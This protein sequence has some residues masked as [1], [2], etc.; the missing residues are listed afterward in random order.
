MATDKKRKGT[1]EEALHRLEGIVE[2]LEKGDVPLEE[3]L[4]LYEEG[5]RLSKSCGERLSQAELS[6]KR[7]GRDLEGNLKL[8]EGEGDE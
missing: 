8:F 1:F 3:A 5:I 4:K 6:L 2:Q 7:L